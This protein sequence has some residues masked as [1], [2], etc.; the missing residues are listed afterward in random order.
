VPR[1]STSTS[2]RWLSIGEFAAATQLSA[3]ALRL[4]DEQRLL[5]PARIEPNGYRYYRSEQVE[6]GRLIRTLREMGLPL[7]DIGRV[8]GLAPVQAQRL[9][10]ELAGH[11]ER[12]HAQ[13][14]RSFQTALG[15]LHGASS[16]A[17]PKIIER[18]LP[19]AVVALREFTSNRYDFIERFRNEVLGIEALLARAG[20]ATASGSF[21]RLLEP[22]SDD[23]G[24]LEAN[25]PLAKRAPLPPG[26]TLGESSA[27][28]CASLALV[29]RRTH[30]SD[31]LAALDALFDW[32]D[33]HACHATGVPILTIA[34]RGDGLETE[35]LWAY[36][37]QDGNRS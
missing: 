4:Y 3:K 19:A 23:E 1:V 24:R 20:I 34:D 5:I 15:M 31:V 36:E 13:S 25:V 6:R 21:C 8:V 17:L 30:G 37:P 9:L 18:T 7:S 14:R 28:Q 27:A 35:I 32:F 12:R 33:R 16:T 26:L 29:N 2:S 10:G 11:Q 22:L